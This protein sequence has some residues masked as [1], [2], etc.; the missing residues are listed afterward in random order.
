MRVRVTDKV[1]GNLFIRAI[2]KTVSRGTTVILT[3]DQF[4]DSMTQT[5]VLMGFL[6]PLDEVED[7]EIKGLKYRNLLKN[8]LSL[9]CLK[10][11]VPANASFFV[12]DE[13]L[14]TDE[15]HTALSLGYIEQEEDNEVVAQNEAKKAEASAAAKE[16]KKNSKKVSK[17]VSKKTSKKSKKTKTVKRIKGNNEDPEVAVDSDDVKVSVG[18]PLQETDMGGS[19]DP[20]EG[21]VE[22]SLPD[23][24]KQDVPDGMHVHDPSGD[25]VSV[26]RASKP[27][28]IGDDLFV[29]GDNQPDELSFV[30]Q[31]QLKE[32]ANKSGINIDDVF[33]NN[34]E[35]E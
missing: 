17:K 19:V 1:K 13:F 5:A 29:D 9:K 31:E 12:P 18:E 25:G 14:D 35:V 4:H 20:T 15:I 22:T 26:R 10:R 28:G 8:A 3:D 33:D 21:Q 32:R 34:S 24:V 23:P 7:F 27:T 6:E 16:E 11:T 2:K 30:D